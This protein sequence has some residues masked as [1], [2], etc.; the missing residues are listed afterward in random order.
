MYIEVIFLMLLDFLH[1]TFA[2]VLQQ[3]WGS[4]K[5]YLSVLHN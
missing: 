5:V 2:L 4:I 1:A 3:H